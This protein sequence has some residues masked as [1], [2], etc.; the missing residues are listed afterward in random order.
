M[1]DHLT[2]QIEPAGL[3]PVFGVSD[4]GGLDVDGAAGQPSSCATALT[5][6]KANTEGQA[7]APVGRARLSGPPR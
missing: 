4:G 6:A 2:G 3:P 1:E 7:P 5:G